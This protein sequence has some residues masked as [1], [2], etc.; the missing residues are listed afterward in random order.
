MKNKNEEQK[1][2]KPLDEKHDNRYAN[3]FGY[4]SE[5]GVV[6]SDCGRFFGIKAAI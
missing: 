4:G 2:R 3:L 6:C 5:T 1:I